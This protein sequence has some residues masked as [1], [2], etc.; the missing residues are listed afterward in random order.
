M[1]PDDVYR[2]LL[3]RLN[4]RGA[5]LVLG[6]FPAVNPQKMDMVD[7]TDDDAICGIQIKPAQTNLKWTWIVAAWDFAF[8]R[9]MHAYVQ[10]YLATVAS[11]GDEGRHAHRSEVHLGEVIQA[12][13]ESGL[14]CDRV[15]F[16]QGTYVDIGTPEDMAVAVERLT[17]GD[18]IPDS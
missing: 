10:K 3:D 14:A 17:K 7:L 9:F 1:Q 11:Q 2:R 16:P 4:V 12:G 5:D 8:T 13:I 6:L 18:A 15:F